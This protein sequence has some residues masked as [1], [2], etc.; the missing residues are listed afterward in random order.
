MANMITSGMSGLIAYQRAIDVAA[1]NIANANTD[2]YV[3]QRVELSTQYAPVDLYGTSI[4][5]VKVDGVRREVNQY[6]I[7]QSRI[8]RSGAGRA[9]V[10]ATQA[11]RIS[12]LLGSTTIGLDDALQSLQNAFEALSV[13]PSSL[14]ARNTL[15]NELDAAFDR[16]KVIDLRLR[17]F[18]AEVNGRLEGEVG[19]VNDLL[20][21]ISQL[22][23]KV[24]RSGIT[25]GISPSNVLDERDRLLD[26]LASKIGFTAEVEKNETITLK[27]L[28]GKLLVQGS[29]SAQLSLGEG[30]YD[31]D[32]PRLLINE[33]GA[34]AAADFSSGVSSGSMGGLIDA[35]VQLITTTRNEMGRI[36]IGLT[37]ALNAQNAA[38]RDL[39]GVP[40]GSLL[41]TGTPMTFAAVTNSPESQGVSL[42]PTVT[43]PSNELQ[44]SDFILS[45]VGAGWEVTRADTGMVVAHQ[46]DGSTGAPLQFGGLS[47]VVGGVG[48]IMA[49]DSFLIRPTSAAV[50]GFGL[51]ISDPSLI[52]AAA[53]TLPFGAG[54]NQNVRA[55]SRLLSEG[56]LD[57][58][59]T[60]LMEASARLASRVGSHARSAQLALD[61]QSLAVEETNRQRSDMYGVSL[62]EEAANLMRFQQA[63]QASAAV[64]RV[65]NE[66]FDELLG[67]TR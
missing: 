23:D 32:E 22:N 4:G 33:V 64:I 34:T 36:A 44:S 21:Q 41:A 30:L 54:D 9:E 7:D 31:P 56:Y 60:S 38:G 6:L 65:A 48:E 11:Q 62:D 51:V 66:L 10:V 47:V 49:G 29:R 26:K 63:Y 42:V 19:E 5:G 58:G 17:Q 3:R 18:N 16:F 53:G 46:G 52:A 12:N 43:L 1:Q 35:R 45:R 24:F 50:S 14:R 25:V 67:A 55:M 27:S 59:K 13:E 8:A 37:S 40:G 28:D 61:V 39:V 20:S 2:G 57:G 15:L